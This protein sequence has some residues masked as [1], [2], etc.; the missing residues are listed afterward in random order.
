VDDLARAVLAALG[1]VALTA[2]RERGYALRSRC[3]LVAD[4]IGAFEVLAQDGSS[5]AHE[6]DSKKAIGMYKEA[7]GEAQK[8]GL[9]WEPAPKLM[10]PQAKLT[11]LVSLSREAG[12]E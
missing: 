5:K 11:K 9:P 12:V 8:A 3:D 6:V 7:I 1:I 4:G 2:A 10:K